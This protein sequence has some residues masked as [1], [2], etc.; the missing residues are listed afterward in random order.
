MIQNGELAAE[1]VKTLAYFFLALG[2]VCGLTLIYFDRPWVAVFGFLGLLAGFLLFWLRRWPL[3][4][5]G[6]GEFLHLSGLRAAAHLRDL[7]RPDR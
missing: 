3:M 1:T 7:L 6:L 2:V 5:L 4:S